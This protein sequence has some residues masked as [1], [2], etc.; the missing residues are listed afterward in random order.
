MY[1]GYHNTRYS[2]SEYQ[3]LKGCESFVNSFQKDMS[4]EEVG[5]VFGSTAKS[6]IIFSE[7]SRMI[8]QSFK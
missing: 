7:R 3:L 4:Y 8:R 1:C 2:Q 5:I 6:L